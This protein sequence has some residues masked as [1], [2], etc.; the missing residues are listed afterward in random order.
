MCLDLLFSHTI[1]RFP[2]N[3]PNILRRNWGN[4][5][6][7]SFGKT[8][9][10][11]LWYPVSC[12]TS[13]HFAAVS[14]LW[15]CVNFAAVLG[16]DVGTTT[17]HIS[18]PNLLSN[19]SPGTTNVHSLTLHTLWRSA[20]ALVRHTSSFVVWGPRLQCTDNGLSICHCCS[21]ILW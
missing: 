9:Y 17:E 6:T 1:S 20:Q 21:A 4:Y 14:T 15:L 13:H 19:K 10:F 8:F 11:P 18:S 3:F 7:F 5:L 16:T 12:V 2:T